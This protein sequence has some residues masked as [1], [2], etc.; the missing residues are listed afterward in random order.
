MRND[1][2]VREELIDKSES[3]AILVDASLSLAMCRG[4]VRSIAVALAEVARNLIGGEDSWGL[5]AF[6]DTFQIIKDFYEPYNN[7]IRAKIGGLQHRGLSLLPD[8]VDLATKSLAKTGE[9][10]KIL[11]LITDGVPMGYTDIEEK[12][13][14]SIKNAQ[15]S[16]VTPIII[17]LG[18]KNIK[19]MFR[20]S[21]QV[22]NITGLMK[23]FVGLYHETHYCL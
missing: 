12:F 17:G 2:F 22:E 11:L 21:C 15:K 7:N 13:I 16:N 1:I 4:D 18:S 19:K 3:W 6:N 9:D 8:A 20:N 5:F 23:Q 10:V 14:Y